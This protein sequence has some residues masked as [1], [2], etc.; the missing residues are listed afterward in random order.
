MIT[1][2]NSNRPTIFL[3]DLSRFCQEIDIIRAFEIFGEIE[4][5]RLMR[6][7][8]DG[9]CLGYGFLTFRSRADAT[10]ALESMNGQL[11]VG[12]KLK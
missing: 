8:K 11:L 3:G 12:R 2:E 7:K 5:I 1:T 10:K 4:E 6:S 9:K